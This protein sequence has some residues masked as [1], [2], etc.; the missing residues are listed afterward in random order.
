MAILDGPLDRMGRAIVAYVEL[1]VSL[2]GCEDKIAS[3][4]GTS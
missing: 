3:P 1:V 2:A 4:Y